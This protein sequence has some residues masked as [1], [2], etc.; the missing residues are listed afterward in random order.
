MQYTGYHVAPGVTFVRVR[1]LAEMFAP[2]GHTHASFSAWLTALQLRKT[3][4]PDGH[5]YVSMESFQL[6]LTTL[7]VIGQADLS[8]FVTPKPCTDAQGNYAPS[9]IRSQLR[10]DHYANYWRLALAQTFLCTRLNNISDT[11]FLRVRSAFETAAQRLAIALA[12][13]TEHE[14]AQQAIKAGQTIP[15][16]E[17]PSDAPLAEAPD[18]GVAAL[19]RFASSRLPDEPA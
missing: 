9:V 2:L 17:I 19:I 7:T 15:E 18:G 16:G 8:T 4:M 3:E 10:A 6:A 12:R 5:E 14:L 13:I 1:E 11:V